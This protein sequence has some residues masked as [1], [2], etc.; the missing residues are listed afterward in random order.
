[1]DMVYTY[2]YECI[3]LLSGVLAVYLIRL[4]NGDAMTCPSKL[5]ID[6]LL[7]LTCTT[8]V[9]QTRRSDASTNCLTSRLVGICIRSRYLMIPINLEADFDYQS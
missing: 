3:R 9:D 2:M 7:D 1:M 8:Q 5:D 6:V 4:S